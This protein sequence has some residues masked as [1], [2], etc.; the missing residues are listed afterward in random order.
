MG[1]KMSN[2]YIISLKDPSGNVGGPKANMDN[3]RFL[4]KLG[5]K[6]IYAILNL[7]QRPVI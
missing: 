6:E 2:N 5:F 7:F 4:K 1:E 3:I